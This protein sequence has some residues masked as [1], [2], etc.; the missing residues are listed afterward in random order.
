MVI[1]LTASNWKPCPNK[2]NPVDYLDHYCPALTKQDL[3]EH[4]FGAACDVKM[5]NLQER[6]QSV[7]ATYNF[8]IDE[9][10]G[11]KQL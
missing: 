6:V 4:L 1:V 10:S 9:T 3:G 5:D 11:N 2:G 7:I 8:D